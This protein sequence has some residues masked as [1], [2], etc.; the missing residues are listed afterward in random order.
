[1]LAVD[2]VVA[3]AIAVPAAFALLCAVA[4][5]INGTELEADGKY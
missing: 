1:L 2:F 3:A 4:K 5:T